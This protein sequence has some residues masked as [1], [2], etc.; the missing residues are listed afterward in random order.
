M[1]QWQ[2]LQVTLA[3]RRVLAQALQV[4]SVLQP[5]ELAPVS[6]WVPRRAPQHQPAFSHRKLLAVQ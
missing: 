1:G 5:R 2:R 3:Q 4:A 6:A